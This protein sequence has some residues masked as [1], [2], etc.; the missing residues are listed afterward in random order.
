MSHRG[1]A[2]RQRERA[3]VGAEAPANAWRIN[4]PT[5]G[6]KAM[7]G[8]LVQVRTAIHGVA[9][10]LGD[11]RPT[12]AILRGPAPES[13]VLACFGKIYRAGMRMDRFGGTIRL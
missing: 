3:V 9:F 8:C 4:S 10:G 7:Q 5:P 11:Q 12:L 13:D 1:S 6:A 2:R